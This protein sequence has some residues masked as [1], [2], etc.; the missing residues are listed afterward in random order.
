M[1]APL[2]SA[3]HHVPHTLEARQKMSASHRARRQ[4]P[5]FV[6]EQMGIRRHA[7][8]GYQ[9]CFDERTG[10]V[11]YEHRVVM[12][13]VL[14]RP[15]L[16]TETVHHINGDRADNRPE[17]L[18]LHQ[19]KHGNGTRWTCADCGSHNVVAAVL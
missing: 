16:P 13:K 3:N 14:G 12:E 5:E 2:G 6:R 15:L 10:R 7:H 1:G 9:R 11:R 4:R 17:N 19:G 8:H 18:Q